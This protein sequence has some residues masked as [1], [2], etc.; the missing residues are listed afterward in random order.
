[1]RKT[2]IQTAEMIFLLGGSRIY[3]FTSVTQYRAQEKIK[4]V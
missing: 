4:G 1:M 3:T 2:R